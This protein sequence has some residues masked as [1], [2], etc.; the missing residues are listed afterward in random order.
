MTE[1]VLS[2]ARARTY[3]IWI[4]AAAAAWPL[5]QFSDLRS[6]AD[7]HLVLESTAMM[8]A[9]GCGLIA[10]LRFKA[11][12]STDFLVLSAGFGGVALLEAVHIV[13]STPGV[14]RLLPSALASVSPWS[15][16]LAR[17]FLA[18]VLILRWRYL[19]RIGK[20]AEVDYPTQ[21]V[22][23]TVGS[24]VLVG[25]LVFAFVPLPE[26]YH[27]GTFFSRPW[28]LLPLAVFGTAFFGHLRSRLWKTNRFEHLM[29]LSLLSGVAAQ[30]YISQ[31]ARLYGTLF[32][33][34]HGLKVLSY[35]F[36]TTGLLI[37]VYGVFRKVDEASERLQEANEM[38]TSSNE[39]LEER[40]RAQFMLNTTMR[41]LHRI[42]MTEYES[43]DDLFA[44]YLDM[45]CRMLA[46]PNGF[47]SEIKDGV[48][49]ARASR[50]EIGLEKGDEVPLKDAFCSV[51]TK[52]ENVVSFD[53]T[54]EDPVWRERNV[55]NGH[56]LE[57][58][59]GVPVYRDREMYGTLCFS[60][61]N[62]RTDGFKDYE[63]DIVQVMAQ[64]VSRLLERERA[65]ADREAVSQMKDEFLSVVSHELRTPLTSIR[66][67]LGLVGSGGLGDLSDK[68]LR[69]V[70]IATDN[71]D[72]L[73]RLIN[74]ILDIERITS[75]Q[76]ALE[77]VDCDLQ[78]L[79]E[80][81]V[82]ALIPVAQEVGVTVESSVPELHVWGD[83][84][85][86]T[87]TMTNLI[88]NAIK[89]SPPDT[90]VRVKANL[91]GR[92][93]VI[94]VR[95]E[96]RGIPSDKTT[97][98]FERFKQVDA[99]D[100][101]LKG[102][103]GLGLAIC[104]EIVEKHGGRIWVT[105]TEGR[106]STFFFT[107][108][109]ADAA[110]DRFPGRAAAA[111]RSTSVLIVE[112]DVGLADVLGE[113]LESLGILVLKAHSGAEAL[114]IASEASIDLIVLDVVIPSGDGYEVVER[115]RL[116]PTLM[117]VPV[118]VYAADEVPEVDRERLRLGHTEFMTKSKVDPEGLRKRAAAILGLPEET[119]V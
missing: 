81:A 13:F 101:R 46:M 52:Q 15:W 25:I 17:I 91:A 6:D 61:G 118:I 98:I 89:F 57:S 86:I 97:S 105:S 77:Q 85:R 59:I 115:F 38:L 34:G 71:T 68:G 63:K 49:T 26:A 117:D 87:Q 64:T 99:S 76:V 2:R 88:S 42:T 83:P 92:E 28:E 11:R 104:K 80:G 93:A 66:G 119:G 58:Y 90:T 62:A 106:G 51:V 36:V 78:H 47:I 9:L 29:V 31:S 21:Q 12:A 3:V 94:Q 67:A 20:G 35:A 84:D 48:W 65:E 56:R 111:T 79:A 19:E 103:T 54:S 60:S 108:P 24:L 45:G 107:L 33:A 5:L 74:D 50:T 95:D 112:D 73:V 18:S 32:M 55:F 30:F 72:R 53:S 82:E 69:M 39:A 4:A 8:L 27:R 22:F 7:I 40:A 23:T 116:D 14:A 44:D 113:V 114:Q 70:E 41:H 75:G 100:S 16:F 102:G 1:A 10:F 109:L 43:Y 96:G 37:E 110:G